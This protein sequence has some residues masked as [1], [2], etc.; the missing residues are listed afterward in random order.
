MTRF[1]LFICA[2]FLLTEANA[3]AES[4]TCENSARSEESL[5]S[6]SK[7]YDNEIRSLKKSQNDAI[8]RAYMSRSTLTRQASASSQAKAKYRRLIS[9]KELEKTKA[10]IEMTAL[11]EKSC[12]PNSQQVSSN[13]GDGREALAPINIKSDNQERGKTLI[14]DLEVLGELHTDGILTD[15]EFNAAK[16]RLLGL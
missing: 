11:L 3:V 1:P 4:V 6:L 12:S 5:T 14:E 9:A 16:R 13:T 2:L 7:A 10:I 8:M 15:E